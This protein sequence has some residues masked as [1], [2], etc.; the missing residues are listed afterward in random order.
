MET[1][2]ELIPMNLLSIGIDI[3]LIAVLLAMWVFWWKQGKRTERVE[4]G[5]QEAA[6]Q[7]QEATALLDDALNQIALLQRQGD[8]QADKKQAVDHAALE[9]VPED[10]LDDDIQ[11]HFSSKARDL[12]NAQKANLAF[13]SMQGASQGASVE[14][15]VERAPEP[16]PQ[17][18]MDVAQILRMQREGAS[19]DSIADTLNMPLAQVKLM[20]MLQ[21][22]A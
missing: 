14:R 21:K 10:T 20:L 2:S 3:V 1:W 22:G 8:L 6:A 11:P 12:L 5:L 17:G 19:L 18:V 9:D 16:S 4:A 7:L 13:S 15:T